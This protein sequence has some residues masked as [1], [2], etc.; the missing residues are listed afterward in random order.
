MPPEAST[1]TPAE[2]RPSR[3]LATVELHAVSSEMIDDSC[4]G[5]EIG[6]HTSGLVSLAPLVLALD[7][8]DATTDGRI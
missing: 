1:S 4:A 5:S 7:C 3:T 6:P 2:T 8:C